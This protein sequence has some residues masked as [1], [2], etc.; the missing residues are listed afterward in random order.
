MRSLQPSCRIPATD[1]KLE[2]WEEGRIQNQEELC[3]ARIAT[4][5]ETQTGEIERMVNGTT[6]PSKDQANELQS[7]LA[8]LRR[9]LTTMA[10]ENQKLIELAKY[11]GYEPWR[12]IS[13]EDHGHKARQVYEQVMGRRFDE[14]NNR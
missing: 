14:R 12:S 4:N 2:S 8:E 13:L 7:I 6:Q 11:Y 10:Y 3:N 5:E 1:F 9:T